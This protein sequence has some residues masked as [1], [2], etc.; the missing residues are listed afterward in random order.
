MTERKATTTAAAMK[1]ATAT[2]T[3]LN[4]AKARAEAH[5]KAIAK[6]IPAACA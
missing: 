2:A 4:G 6:V 1:G 5:A 3:T